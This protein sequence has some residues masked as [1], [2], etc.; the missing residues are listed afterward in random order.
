[1]F[2]L[3]AIKFKIFSYST[4]IWYL[5]LTQDIHT[6]LDIIF[7]LVFLKKLIPNNIL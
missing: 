5:N 4:H 1:M 7:L 3:L 6:D 2:E